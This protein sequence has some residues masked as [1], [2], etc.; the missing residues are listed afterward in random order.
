MVL[1]CTYYVRPLDRIELL[2]A[3]HEIS[4]LRVEMTGMMLEKRPECHRD[5]YIA[6]TRE[7]DI[8]LLAAL[9]Q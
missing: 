9:Q 6:A 2:F 7:I 1:K 8:V 4:E 3:P 5:S